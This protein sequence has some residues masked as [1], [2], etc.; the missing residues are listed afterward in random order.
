VALFFAV[1]LTNEQISNLNNNI[2]YNKTMLVLS[3]QSVPNRRTLVAYKKLQTR[4]VGLRNRTDSLVKDLTR[5]TDSLCIETLSRE[6]HQ[7]SQ[8]LN[9]V[10]DSIERFD[11]HYWLYEYTETEGGLEL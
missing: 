4:K 8:E 3:Q 6:L 1:A 7:V 9:R 5:C 11:D 10:T 2:V